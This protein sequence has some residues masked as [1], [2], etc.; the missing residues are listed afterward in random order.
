MVSR[1]L[2]FA[3]FLPCRIAMVEDK[4]GQSWLITLNMDKTLGTAKLPDEL[5]AL[6]MSVRNNI[7]NILAAGASGDL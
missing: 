4:A 6:G 5:S 7:Y 2:A 3:G 1:D